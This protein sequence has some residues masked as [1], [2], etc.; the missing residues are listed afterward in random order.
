[1]NDKPKNS[2]ILVQALK[3]VEDAQVPEDLREIAFKEAIRLREAGASSGGDEGGLSSATQDSGASGTVGKPLEQVAAR[4]GVEPAVVGEVFAVRGGE[5]QL[6]VGSRSL[7]SGKATGAKQIAL[8]IAGARQATGVE[9]WTPIGVIREWCKH[10]GKFD[11][12]NFGKTV[13][14]MD[15]LFQFTGERQQREVKMRQ[16]AWEQAGEL[17][18]GIVGGE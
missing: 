15:D 7:A 14:A 12:T 16:P 10:Y 2:N 6:A 4:F 8:L 1:M 3:D 5:V 17:V 18:H 9:E 11:S 13:S